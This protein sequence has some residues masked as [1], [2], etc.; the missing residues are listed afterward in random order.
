[1]VICSI[2]CGTH[3][4]YRTSIHTDVLLV[5]ML[6]MNNLGHQMTVRCHHKTTKL[7]I[8]LYITHTCR[9]QY[10]FIY[11]SD[12]LTDYTD[13]I[14]LLIR[15]IGYTDTAGKINKGNMCSGLFLQLHRCLKQCS[16]QRR[17]ILIGY[18]I[19]SQESMNTEILN[20][21]LLHY[22]KALEKLLGG[23]S[24]FC[25]SGIIHNAVAD[26]EISAGI[27]TAA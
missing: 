19:T 3:Q 16:C 18:G 4:I 24:V 14:R 9:Y 11:L 20:T 17:V 12:T 25:I 15:L 1:M 13:I 5:G 21:L 8:Y 10:L 6:L 7:R 26:G 23:K 27:I 2:H 22:L